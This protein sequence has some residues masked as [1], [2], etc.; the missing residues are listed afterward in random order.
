MSRLRRQAAVGLVVAGVASAL[1]L[2]AGA[3]LL[4]TTTTTAAAPTAPPATSA[5]APAP[6]PAEDTTT[7][8]TFVPP[9][10]DPN[11]TTSTLPPPAEPE[12]KPGPPI[13]PKLVFLSVASFAV[14]IAIAATNWIRTRPNRPP[15]PAVFEVSD[16]ASP[17]APTGPDEDPSPDE[18]TRRTL[19]P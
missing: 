16:D 9:A 17:E 10:G 6:A 2:P 14:A 11:A 5:P 13:L 12:D 4:P 19:H 8:S 7:S 3:Q 1:S 15:R 18:P